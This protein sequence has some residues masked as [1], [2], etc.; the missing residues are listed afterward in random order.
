MAVA[1]D[2]ASA[3]SAD[4]TAVTTLTMTTFTV[5]VGANRALA[6]FLTW[7]RTTTTISSG[8]PR[9]DD[10]G[11]PQAMTQVVGAG[12]NASDSSQRTDI[13][14]LLAP[15]SGNKILKVNWT[16]SAELIIEMI[17]FTGVDQGSVGGSFA[18]GTGALGTSATPSIVVTSAT[19]NYTIAI[20]GEAHQ[21]PPGS[22]TQTQ[23]AQ[24]SGA[25]SANNC[26]SY[27]AGAATVTHSYSMT[28]D[29]W[30]AS[31]CEIV[32]VGAAGSS[33]VTDWMI[34]RPDQLRQ[35]TQVSVIPSGSM[36]GR[37]L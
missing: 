17:S 26:S 8:Y 2:L 23:I 32:A 11:T 10:A 16:T 6:V 12:K 1:V 20:A 29:V 7:D 3:N 36:P 34:S 14:G 25:G 18:H 24:V 27:G 21:F 19:N 22:P 15:T 35:H 13:W 37:G 4:A 33:T 31:G 9:W 28:S 5:G 30:C